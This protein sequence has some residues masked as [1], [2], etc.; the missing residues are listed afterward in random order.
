MEEGC[1]YSISSFGSM[2]SENSEVAKG[3]ILLW[4]GTKVG[5]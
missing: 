4:K 3:H 2:L 5:A 1:S